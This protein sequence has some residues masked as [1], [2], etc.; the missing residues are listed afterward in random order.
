M[1]AAITERFADD[2]D[3]CASQALLKIS[4]KLL[5]PYHWRGS[6][7]VVLPVDLPPRIKYGAGRRGFQELQK[8]IHLSAGHH[9][10]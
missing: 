9:L 7:D 4:S 10:N 6:G 5:T 3:L 8:L 1:T 2:D